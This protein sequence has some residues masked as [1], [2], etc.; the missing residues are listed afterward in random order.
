MRQ[1][2]VTAG[3][4]HLDYRAPLPFNKEGAQPWTVMC[5]YNKING[6]YASDHKKLMRE[7]L[8]DEWGHEGLVV[9]DWGAMNDRVEGLKAGVELEMPGAPNGND[10]MILAAVISDHF[11][12]AHKG[13]VK[14]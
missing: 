5:S 11:G 12:H 10:A 1:Q 9:T 14:G 8:K 4:I 6:T 13:G 7:I 3:Y 2:Y